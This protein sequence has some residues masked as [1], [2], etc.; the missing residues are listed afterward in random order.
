MIDH[1]SAMYTKTEKMQKKGKAMNLYYQR[2]EERIYVYTSKYRERGRD[3]DRQRGGGRGERR[4][5]AA[6]MWMKA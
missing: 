3:R 1:V 5:Q 4:N 2:K 6:V